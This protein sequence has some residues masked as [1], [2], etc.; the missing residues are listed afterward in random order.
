MKKQELL[1]GRNRLRKF[2]KPLLALM[3]R[4]ER[5]YWASLYLHGLLLEGGG[6]KTAA[7]IA[8]FL[9][10]DEQALQ[11]FLSQSPWDWEPVRAEMARQMMRYVSSGGG[12]IVDDTG[13]PKKT[14]YVKLKGRIGLKHS[15][16]SSL[17]A[18]PSACLST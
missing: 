7:G 12:W 16:L 9:D 18:P 11:Q 5:R 17:Y 13:F 6:R 4:S 2:L 10:G 14:F 1:N 15:V 8:R 3:G